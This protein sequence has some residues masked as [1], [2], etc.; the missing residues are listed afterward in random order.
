MITP[1]T[2][3]GS[4]DAS[5]TPADSI[6]TS[7]PAPIAIP[8]SARASAGASF[9]P[10]PTIAT[11]EPTRLQLGDRVVLVLGK[12]LGEHLVDA[13]RGAD[14]IGHLL[15]VTRDHHHPDATLVQVAT[16]ASDSGRISSSSA[17]AP[18]TAPSRTT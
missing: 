15:G 5:T 7:V 4:D 9:T 11:V 3:R 1:V 12:H 13:E 14:A 10:S 17:S 16:A 6:A 18:T 8:T 2:P